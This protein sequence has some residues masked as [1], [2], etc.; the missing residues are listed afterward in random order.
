MLTLHKIINDSG[1]IP[2]LL[3]LLNG[4]IISIWSLSSLVNIAKVAEKKLY[5]DVVDYTYD[6]VIYD[7]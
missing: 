4:A 3:L 1:L 5:T 7:I 6:R 2:G